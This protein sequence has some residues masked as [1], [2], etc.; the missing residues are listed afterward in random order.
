MNSLS[1]SDPKHQNKLSTITTYHAGILQSSTHRLLQK[2]S[3]EILKPYGIT[4]MQWMIIGSVLDEG[5]QGVSITD[6]AKKLDT[7]LSYLT[8]TINLLESKGILERTA[9]DKDDRVK[10]VTVNTKFL[11]K[12]KEIETHLRDHLRKVIYK[13]ITPEEF[14]T[15]IQVLQK[16]SK[17]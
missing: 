16:L 2:Y 6:L 7:T 12:C 3:D 9:H 15:Y 1:T 5:E 17:I 4:K 14:L 8:N 11:L 13:D 10:L